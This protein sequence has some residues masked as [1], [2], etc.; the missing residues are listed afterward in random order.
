MSGK[1]KAGEPIPGD[2][3]NPKPG[4]NAKAEA[5]LEK[6]LEKI[7]TLEAKIAALEEGEKEWTE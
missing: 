6:A 2:G 4:S 5:T 3:D 7:E 1:G